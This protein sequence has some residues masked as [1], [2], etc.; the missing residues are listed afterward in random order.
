MAVPKVPLLCWVESQQSWLIEE[1]FFAAGRADDQCFMLT[2]LGWGYRTGVR[3]LS[4]SIVSLAQL[5]FCFLDGQVH[6]QLPIEIFSR[7]SSSTP[8]NEEGGALNN[9]PD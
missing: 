7:V 1:A 9:A 3:T 8:S 4:V 6:L 2:V 5:D